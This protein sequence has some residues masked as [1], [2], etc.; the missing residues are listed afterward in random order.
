MFNPI[1]AKQR[2]CIVEYVARPSYHVYRRPPL[3]CKK[4]MLNWRRLVCSLHGVAMQTMMR[5]FDFGI[6]GAV[7][8][9]PPLSGC[10]RVFGNIKTNNGAGDMAKQRHACRGR[11]AECN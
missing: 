4:A 2:E 7:A 6:A 1:M 10:F 11:L 5:R 9:C 3:K 8:S